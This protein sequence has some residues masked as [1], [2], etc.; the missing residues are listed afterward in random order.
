MATAGYEYYQH[1][2]KLPPIKSHSDILNQPMQSFA[3]SLATTTPKDISKY[4]SNSCPRL[5]S[6]W[7]EQENTQ[8]GIAM[9]AKDWKAL[10]LEGAQG[11]A[12]WLNKTSG[13]CGDTINIHAALYGTSTNTSR[14]GTR[15]IEAL[16]I[17]WYQGSGARQ[18]WSSGPIKLKRYKNIYPRDAT[19]MME[20]KWRTTLKFKI[21]ANWVPGFYL[22]ITRS[23]DGTLENVAPF[24]V[25][26]PIGSSKLMVMHSFITWNAYND[27][28]GRSA[29]FG[30]GATK[31]EMRSDRSRIFS[32]DRP[33]VGSGGFSLHRDGISLVQFLEKQGINS[34]QFSDFDLDSWPSI[35]SNYSGIILGGHPE[36]FTRRIFET[37]VSARNTGTNIAILGGNTGIWQVR[38]APSRIG[39]NRH[40]VIYRVAKEDPVVDLRQITIQFADKRL[41][42]PP[43]LLTGTLADGVHVY[44]NLKVG[45]IP[46]WLQ[47]PADAAINGISPDSEVEHTVSTLAS[48][49]KVHVLFSGIM[50]YRDAQTVGLLPRPVSIAQSVWF[51][52]PSG[53]AVFNAGVTTWSCD[54]IET[55][56]YSTVSAK[57]RAIMSSLTS[58]ILHLWETKAVGRSLNK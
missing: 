6:N 53:A 1:D 33:L 54:L 21:D 18:V 45:T 34:D 47:M 31:T 42:I 23:T 5:P 50:H 11:S 58:Q 27:F 2:K 19:R 4:P 13:N 38:M 35:T 14:A 16:R 44:G 9:K 46:K 40:I 10:N 20:T 15:M 26:S 22:F 51:T 57:S 48:P 29:Y 25:H 8:H 3:E 30:S 12:L 24:V 55:C 17:G 32:L 52:T 28:G 43:T 36:Y 41:N 37:L 7:V 39:P 56:V 49:P